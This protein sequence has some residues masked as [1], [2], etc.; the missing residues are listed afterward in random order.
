MTRPYKW[1]ATLVAP[2]MLAAPASAD[3]IGV[4]TFPIQILHGSLDLG[5]TSA[6]LT[7]AGTRGLSLISGLAV[8]GGSVQLCDGCRPGEEFSL[9][10]AWIGKDLSGTA[11][12]QGRTF[13]I[14]GSNPLDANGVVVFDGSAVAPPVDEASA[15]VI[16]PFTFTGEI[17]EW[18]SNDLVHRYP[19]FGEGTATIQLNTIGFDGEP[20]W[21]YQRALYRFGPNPNPKPVPEPA[22]LVLLGTGLCAAAIRG[23]CFRRGPQSRQMRSRAPM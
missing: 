22:T 5:V 14:G 17:L 6:T 16:A 19:L 23:R 2:L 1:M 15:T 7:L 18:L 3:P 8:L 11:T 21:F 13:T 10:A 4:E 9:G 12:V 20:F